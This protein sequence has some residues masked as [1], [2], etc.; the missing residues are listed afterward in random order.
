MVHSWGYTMAYL[1]GD[2]TNKCPPMT[3]NLQKAKMRLQTE[4]VGETRELSRNT[5]RMT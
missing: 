1:G 2:M 4:R 3:M 5:G